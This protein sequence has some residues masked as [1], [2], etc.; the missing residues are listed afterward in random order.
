MDADPLTVY[1]RPNCSS[2]M[3]LKEYLAR[4]GIVFRSV[5]VLED[6]AALPRLAQQGIRS[7]PVVQRGDGRFAY[8]QFLDDVAAFLGTPAPARSTL[9]AR[10]SAERLLVLLRAS[11]RYARQLPTERVHDEIAGLQRSYGDIAFHVF[12]IVEAFVAAAR[13]GTL[14][15]AMIVT[16]I[17]ASLRT[18]DELAGYGE[19]ITALFAAWWDE[20]GARESWNR[21]IAT[22][23]GTKSLA[24]TFERSTWHAAQHVR[25]LMSLWR[26]LGIVLDGP[27]PDEAFDG[28]PL[29]VQ[30]RDRLESHEETP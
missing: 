17:P 4:Q 1:W 28:L 19:R 18:P 26:E 5:N 24:D 29:P 20:H 2:C 30:V 15:D 9:D 23:Y 7:I 13:G 12:R 11:A 8:A 16:S 25:Q 14:S 27:L 3:R 6:A 22:D 21:P 10:A